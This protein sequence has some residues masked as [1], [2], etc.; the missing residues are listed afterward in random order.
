MHLDGLE[1]SNS[2][3]PPGIVGYLEIE[4]TSKA[5][6]RYRVHGEHLIIDDWLP[7]CGTLEL[8]FCQKIIG[9]NVGHRKINEQRCLPI[10]IE[11]ANEVFFLRPPLRAFFVPSRRAKAYATIGA[12]GKRL[13]SIRHRRWL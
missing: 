3:R 6:G 9:E 8:Q 10:M 5:V 12:K 2:A 4:E 1:A 13:R 7:V 11:D